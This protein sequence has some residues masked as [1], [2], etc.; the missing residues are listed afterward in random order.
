VAD[1]TFFIFLVTAPVPSSRVTHNSCLSCKGDNKHQYCY[2]FIYYHYHHYIIIINVIII[3]VAV[4]VVVVIVHTIQDIVE[5]CA[6]LFTIVLF[7]VS[8]VVA[9]SGREREEVFR[10][11]L[12]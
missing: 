12:R 6:L 3:I 10:I 11:D 7:R 4:I 2:H 1:E 5:N 8:E 9:Q